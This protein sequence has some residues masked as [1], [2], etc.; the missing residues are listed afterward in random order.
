ME[1][2]AVDM[3][4]GLHPARYGPLVC[5]DLDALYLCHLLGNHSHRLGSDVARQTT[6]VKPIRSMRSALNNY[7]R[8]L[9]AGAFSFL[10]GGRPG[11]PVFR[12]S[13][14]CRALSF[15]GLSR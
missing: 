5:D 4:A 3:G 14:S 10:P 1:T 2:G 9:S 6:M 15:P 8:F 13:R 11:L 7:L 12:A